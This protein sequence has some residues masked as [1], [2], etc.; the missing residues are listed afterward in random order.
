[1]T[2]EPRPLEREMGNLAITTM[3]TYYQS[4]RTE[5]QALPKGQLRSRRCQ[6]HRVRP[7]RRVVRSPFY[8]S[9]ISPL[10]LAH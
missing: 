6:P 8:G 2:R 5:S 10:C 1:M 4:D 7:E 9:A 3:L